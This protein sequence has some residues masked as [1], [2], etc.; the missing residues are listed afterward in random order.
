MKKEDRTQKETFFNL[1]FNVSL[2]CL[3][4]WACACRRVDFLILLTF[5]PSS[6]SA[7]LDL[8]CICWVMSVDSSVLWPNKKTPVNYLCPWRCSTAIG[9]NNNNEYLER[10][11]RRG[12]KRL[13]V[14]YKYILSKFNAYN[15]N[16][17]IHARTHTDS[18][19]HA[20]AH[21]HTCNC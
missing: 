9:S 1:F 7:F 17:H 12:P 16:A 3:S 14:P 4:P 13:H 15:M 5:F 20:R 21:T 8:W 19:A 2:N 6:C 10:L 11:V 18:Y